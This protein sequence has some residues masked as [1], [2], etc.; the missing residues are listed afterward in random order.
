MASTDQ[1]TA[2]LKFFEFFD[3][4]GQLRAVIFFKLTI[5][6]VFVLQNMISISSSTI[7]DLSS[8]VVRVDLNILHLFSSVQCVF[9]MDYQF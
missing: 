9:R 7:N 2:R 5:F 6:S 8:C 1:S 3:S 4:Y